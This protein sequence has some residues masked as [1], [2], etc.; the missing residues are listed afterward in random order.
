MADSTNN[1][2]EKVPTF[3]QA[4]EK[5]RAGFRF[6]SDN[7]Y[8]IVAIIVFA[9]AGFWFY[10]KYVV[11]KFSPTYV[12]NKEFVRDDIET[13]D[14]NA[15]LSTDPKEAVDITFYY[16]NWCPY[17]KKAR[18]EWDKIKETYDRSVINHHQIFFKEVDC[19]AEENAD[20][21]KEMKIEGYPTIFM[22]KN[23]QNIEYDAKPEY[24][25]LELFIKSVLNNSE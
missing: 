9:C 16:T 6:M 13:T 17:C 23:G 20:L 4:V 5:V 3:T 2:R 10:S 18:P 25:T 8:W 24:K 7:K 1:L 11:P 19:E 14:D 15:G 22:R 21:V 12:A